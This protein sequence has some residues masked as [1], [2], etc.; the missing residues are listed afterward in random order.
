VRHAV[1]V[2]RVRSQI[3]ADLH[4]G[5]GASLSRIAIL[6]DVVRQQA[7][8]ALPAAMPA[9]DAIGDNARAVIDD[10]SD[11]VW[12]IDP[13][14]D[15]LQHVVTRIRALASELF[16][17]QR[18]GCTIEAPA[19]AARVTLASEQRR[20]VYLILKESLTN[21]LRH[22]HA[23]HVVVRVDVSH[24]TLHLRVID[25]GVGVDGRSSGE[26]G[27]RRGGRGLEN[28]RRRVAALHGD[29]SV[30]AG[31]DGRG[32]GVTVVLPLEWTA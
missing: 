4:D 29:V 18:I 25:D 28:I 22:A 11:A 9:L 15:T 17:G 3:A 2:E 26:S 19:D 32:T 7:Q 13:R 10:M 27:L 5:V 24:R 30:G 14:L 1:A 21:V 12:L 16:D 20:H 23:T 6:S 31:V 8:T